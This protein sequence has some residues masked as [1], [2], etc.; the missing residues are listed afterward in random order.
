MLNSVLNVRVG[1]LETQPQLA[2]LAALL[3]WIVLY[4]ARLKE[5]VFFVCK[6]SLLMIQQVFCLY[7]QEMDLSVSQM[8][9]QTVEFL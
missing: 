4:A 9:F 2:L 6:S 5:S 8:L 3:I 1:T 7:S